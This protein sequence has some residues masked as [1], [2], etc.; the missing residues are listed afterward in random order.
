MDFLTS[1]PELISARIT[2]GPGS[3]SLLAAA[4]AWE[5]LGADLAATA[6]T[7]SSVVSS[8]SESAWHGSSATAMAEL[9]SAYTCWLRQA[10]TDAAEAARHATA[11]AAA[12]DAAR[13]ATVPLEALAGNRTQWVSLVVSNILGFNAPAIA[14]T[15]AEYE[16]M[17]AQNVVAMSDYYAGAAVAVTRLTPWQALPTQPAAASDVTLVIGGSGY[18]LPS[19]SYV[20][21]VLANYVTPSFPAFTATN[22]QALPT[23]AQ[24]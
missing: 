11:A 16:R 21:S 14:A 23:P 24:S 15:E 9:A 8:L 10:A 7:F 20:N 5:G 1:P 6:D 4:S 18:P 13:A 2:N 3:S 12:H 19:Q 22:V 17:W